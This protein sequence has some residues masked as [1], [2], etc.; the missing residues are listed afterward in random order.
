[1]IEIIPAIIPRSLDDLN[2]KYSQV[3][4]FTDIVQIDVMDGKF[5]PSVSWP[6]VNNNE[7]K[8]KSVIAEIDFNFEV[9]L[10]VLNPEVVVG[11]WIKA[12]AKRVIVHIESI[13]NFL[14]IFDAISGK[15][16]LG[17]ALN[18]NTPNERIYQLIWKIDFIQFMGIEKIGFQ[19]QNFDERVVKKITDLR[20]KFSGIIISVDGGV[21][22]EN[23]PRLIKAGVNRLVSGSAIF[24]SGDIEDTVSKLKN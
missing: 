11:D 9:D 18:T 16:E 13:K 5:V 7:D 24:E 12:G 17:I 15:V 4:H 22:I 1:M 23:A 20:E 19:G 2:K 14:E 21:N 8:E 10:M 3:K 6:Y